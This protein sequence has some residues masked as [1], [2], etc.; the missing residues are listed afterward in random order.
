MGKEKRFGLIV[1]AAVAIA[2]ASLSA[3][4]VV[5]KT[6]PVWQRSEAADGAFPKDGVQVAQENVKDSCAFAAEATVS[7][8]ADYDGGL[9]PI[10]SQ[11]VGETGWAISYAADKKKGPVLLV[12]LGGDVKRLPTTVKPGSTHTFA[13]RS[14]DGMVTVFSDSMLRARYV[15]R[16]VPNLE[17]V[18][19]GCF[20]PEAKARL[21]S[22]KLYGPD[23]EYRLLGE[24]KL[25][26]PAVRSGK[27]WSVDCPV[28][29]EDAKRPKVFCWGD[30]IMLGYSPALRRVLDGRA[31]VYSWC[32]FCSNPE[33]KDWTPWVE[34]SGIEP[35]DF[36][37]FNNGLH[38][39]H[40][41]EGAVSDARAEACYR[42]LVRAFR[43]GAPKAKLVYLTTTPLLKQMPAG[44]KPDGFNPGNAVVQRLN[45][46][47]TNVMREEDVEVLDLYA[48]MSAHLDYANGGNDI[49][50]WTKDKGYP[51]IARTI[52]DKLFGK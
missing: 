3:G 51:L 15:T 24:E 17:P 18:K 45:R 34:A 26:M 52:S 7:F 49:Y 28:K 43:K 27:G 22:A 36:V 2:G 42:G 35:F 8:G 32:G 1:S 9:L 12:D 39:L 5:V 23:E 37:V 41:K 10:L 11:R 40:W 21:V 20:P 33:V 38:S 29:V 48:V 47:A 30:S 16:I 13:I 50:H 31:Y 6:A 46:I 4:T 44:Q 25:P 19:V 14:R